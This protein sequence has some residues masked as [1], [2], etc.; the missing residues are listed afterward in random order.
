MSFFEKMFNKN[1]KE[2]A[3]DEKNSLENSNEAMADNS[4]ES[5]DDKDKENLE[6]AKAELSKIE[7]LAIELAQIN[8]E[9]AAENLE[10][11]EKLRNN[12]KVAAGILTTL[13]FGAAM[14]LSFTERVNVT[15]IMENINPLINELMMG[16]TFV[17]TAIAGAM[18]QEK[19]Q[20]NKKFA[21]TTENVSQESS[22]ENDVVGGASNGVAA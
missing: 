15:D 3:E 2:G 5:G 14:V 8:P 22:S 20:D 16:V 21:T 17:A 11:N 10:K 6:K 4:S 12:L 18:T 7:A 1:P 19:I 13:G 9:K